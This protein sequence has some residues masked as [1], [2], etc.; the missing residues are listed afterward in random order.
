[1]AKTPRSALPGP[2]QATVRSVL[3]ALKAAGK[4]STAA[5]YRRHGV[6]DEVLGVL[7]TD[8]TSLAKRVGVDHEV[9]LG[10][11]GT[12]VHEARLL[13]TR[14]ADTARLTQ[15]EV[16][17][18]A[19]EVR[20]YVV[21]DALAQMTV[22]LPQAQELALQWIRRS[23]EFVSAAGW[24]VIGLLAKQGRLAES[25]AR[26]LLAQI[27]RTIHDAPNRTRHT[28]NTALISIGGYL[29]AL[30]DAALA[31][32]RAIGPVEV[33][34]GETGCKTPDAA[35]YIAKMAARGARK[36]TAGHEA[37][38]RK[39][40]AVRKTARDGTGSKA[41]VGG[42]RARAKLPATRGSRSARRG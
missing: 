41:A 36:K 19:G 2:I 28:M 38:S 26:R 13:A 16:N 33:D 8:L 34:H 10:L 18:W 24:T 42:G 32:A 7:T 5:V 23:E 4:P 6:E 17:R 30:R 39:P 35:E 31:T 29:E 1:M 40:T 11:W 14:V 20:D 21:D 27:G 15:D 37:V 22:R 3:D 25:E 12:G 9:A